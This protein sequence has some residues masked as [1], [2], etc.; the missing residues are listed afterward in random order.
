[1]YDHAS[2]RCAITGGAFYSP[3]LIRFPGEYLSDYF[4]ADY[5]AG[6]IRKLDPL[7]N[8]VVTF[9]TGISF[10]VD[11]KVSDD[12]D[13]Y[14]LA[15]GTG[16]ATGVVY[17]ITYG[18]APSIS[19]HPASRTVAPGG[20]V[21]FSV[22]ASGQAP[23]R[24]Q[25]QRNGANIAGATAPDYRISSVSQAD[26]GARFRAVV[27]NA[28]GSVTSNQ[29]VLTVSANRAPTATITQPAA[30][31]LYRGGMVINYS[32]TG[33]DPEQGNLP[34]SAFTWRVDFHH[35]AHTHP[36]IQPRNGA[37]GGSFTIPTTGHTETNV[38][39]RI[40]LT[41]RDS[42]GLTHTTQ[43]DIRPRKVQLTLATNPAGLLLRLDGQPVTT[44]LTFQ[45]VVGV[46]RTLGAMSPQASGGSTYQFVSWS[47]GGAATHNI[48]TPATNMTYRATYRVS[49]SGTGS[50]LSVTYFN[51]ADLT[52]TTV[53]R[54]DPIVAFTWGAGSPAAAIAA[55]TFSARWTG[56]VQAQF[57]QVYTFYTQSD[58]GVRLW[59]NGQLL[60]NNWTDHA[61][62]ENSGTI[63]LTAGQRYA[64]RMEFY[65][66]GGSAIA[67]LFW[68]SASTPKELVPR[69]R[70]FP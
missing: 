38:W 31:L 22:R 47:D 64:I 40:Y 63:S 28:A 54:T 20:S 45:S 30:G 19:S 1:V 29:A 62:T 37:T 51:N 5:C 13:L 42:G 58:D 49:S 36:F 67:R 26:N 60:V 65:E 35:D 15:R 10:P 34:A 48:S 69:T 39:Y 56:Q 18:A 32:G 11:L 50:G 52:G 4:F 70:L 41:V 27:S 9:A 43:R 53:T 2:G 17:R 66:K 55:D 23:L 25:W 59:V 8:A 12:G 44:P 33:T 21:T 14:Y 7:D 3:L 24:Y 46:V 57:T 6:W 61:T 68:S 16:A